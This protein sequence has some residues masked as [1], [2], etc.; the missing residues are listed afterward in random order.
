MTTKKKGLKV[1]TKEKI[2]IAKAALNSRRQVV[3]SV[4]AALVRDQQ[5]LEN[6]LEGYSENNSS[7]MSVALEELKDPGNNSIDQTMSALHRFDRECEVEEQLRELN[8]PLWD[9]IIGN[10]YE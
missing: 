10:P 5:A 2:E 8:K 9:K 7:V 4:V 3:Y 1:S 6:F